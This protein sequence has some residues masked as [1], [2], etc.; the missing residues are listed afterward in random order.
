[1]AIDHFGL[2]RAGRVV[3]RDRGRHASPSAA[4]C[5]INPSGG[6]IG[7]ATPSARPACG[8]LARR[9]QAGDRHGR[10]LPGRRSAR[11]RDA[12]H[13]RQRDDDAS[14]SSSSG[15]NSSR[16]LGLDEPSPR[17]HGPPIRSRSSGRTCAPTGARDVPFPPGERPSAWRARRASSTTRSACCS[18]PTSA[19]G[20]SSRCKIF[21]HNAVFMLG[22]EANHYMLVS[23][24]RNFLWRD[25]PHARPDP[26]AGRRPADDR[27]RRS[28]AR[29]AS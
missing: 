2:T 11:G 9:R 27:R 18:S 19:T 17:C 25:G 16:I 28:T 20:R 10:R 13:R 1:M 14:A 3:A 23:H 8:M 24:A 15:R 29:T 6:L 26:A 12:Q 4:S 21:H 5:P 7:A 22:P